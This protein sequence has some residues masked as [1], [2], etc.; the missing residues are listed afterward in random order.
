MFGYLNTAFKR[1]NK[2]T[3]NAV[4]KDFWQDATECWQ[5]LPN[6]AFFFGLL[7]AW[8]VLFHFWGNSIL[9]YV[10]TS[11][12]FS[13]LNDIYNSP[14]SAEDSGHGDFIPPLVIVL[15]WWK[16]K[17]L[18]AL[19]LD[20]WVPGAFIVAFALVLHILGYLVQQPLVS[21]V[22]LLVGLYGLMGLAWGRQW[23]RHSRYPFMLFIFSIPMA[24]HLNFVLFPL[25]VL[26]TALA[27]A[28]AHLIGIGVIRQ[29]TDLIDPSGT[30][31]YEV[32]AECGGMRSVVA[33]VLIATVYAFAILKSPVRKT[34]LILSAIPFAVLGNV[35]RLF[36][37]I[38]A[39]AM[40]GQSWGNY[41]H[42]GG[43]L[44]VFSLLPY[45]PPILGLF[46]LGRRLE[47]QEIPVQPDEK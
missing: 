36:T 28:V 42:Q 23:L 2:N 13:W 31:R 3:D 12:I 4:R 9:G 10:H 11:S 39:A 17:E 29:G 24:S 32:A 40:G 8:I 37:I 19:P 30:F 47:N 34:S 44:G 1:M 6:K 22:A 27:A 18:L 14:N 15:F 20:V 5:R 41:V 43:P 33:V 21:V 46:W 25:R 35:V 26:A 38:V 16:R 45:V 7:A